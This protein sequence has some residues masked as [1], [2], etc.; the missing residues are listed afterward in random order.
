[1]GWPDIY[2]ICLSQ[3][4]GDKDSFPQTAPTNDAFFNQNWA[5]ACW[6][7][8]AGTGTVVGSIHSSECGTPLQKQERRRVGEGFA[9]DRSDA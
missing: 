8:W 6:G 7:R 5:G 3:L 1:M 2:S 4:D 9:R